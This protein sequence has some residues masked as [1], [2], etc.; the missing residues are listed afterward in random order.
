M[1][2][3]TRSNLI[4][5]DCEY[6]ISE[7][8]KLAKLGLIDGVPVLDSILIPNSNVLSEILD[9]LDMG[10]KFVY[11]ISLEDMS[12]DD[13]ELLRVRSRNLYIRSLNMQYLFKGI[14]LCKVLDPS[15]TVKGKYGIEEL[16]NE[17][18]YIQKLQ[19]A[20]CLSRVALKGVM[21]CDGC[22]LISRVED[23]VKIGLDGLE[24]TFWNY[25]LTSI[26]SAWYVD[27]P[28]IP[29]PVVD[30]NIGYSHR[31]FDTLSIRAV[32][33]EVSRLNMDKLAYIAYILDSK[34]ISSS[35]EKVVIVQQIID[36]R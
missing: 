30:S 16:K 35:S 33:E 22:T 8:E 13:L 14:P 34:D 7:C 1:S 10:L 26:N 21:A 36:L 27:K 11:P 24:Y 19:M 12:I 3:N 5:I 17:I 4:I 32:K 6:Y 2:R 15:Y 23:G 20:W 25:T 31:F 29:L 18:G 9:I 28:T